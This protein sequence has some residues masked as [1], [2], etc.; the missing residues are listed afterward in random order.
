MKSDF[1]ERRER[2]IE[3]Y[4][5]WS[6][7]AAQEAQSEYEV[8]HNMA[9][10][11][12]FGQPILVGHHSEK[13]D[14]R[15][16][17]RIEGHFRASAVL[18][19]KSAYYAARAKAAES[20]TAIFSDDP[21]AEE[22]LEDKIKR[23]E[24]RQEMMKKA[25]ALVRKGDLEGLLDMGFTEAWAHMLLTGEGDVTNRKDFASWELSNNN[26]NIR[27]CKERLKKLQGQIK[28]LTA[29]FDYPD[30]GIRIVDNVEENR[31]QIFY[32]GKPSAA[33][34]TEMKSHGFVWAPSQGAWQRHRSNDALYWARRV[35]EKL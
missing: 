1:E 22:K 32:P 21:Q 30:K 28:D 5:E 35:V 20:N 27:R 10:A 14:R 6:E 23:L 19:D 15:C 31:V 18:Q 13:Q 29:E 24:Q 4:H 2:R 16:R 11:I 25:N 12:P 9:Q 33:V 26:A 34:R 3:R 17:G 7:Q 8:G